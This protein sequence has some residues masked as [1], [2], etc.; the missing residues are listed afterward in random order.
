MGA[1]Q[2][3]EDEI[4]IISIRELIAYLSVDK[5][6]TFIALLGIA[7]GAT[8]LV[9]MDT[10]SGG[11]KKKVEAELG[12]L[13]ALLVMIVPGQVKSIGQ[14]RIQFSRYTTLK[15]EDIRRIRQKIPF[16]KDASAIKKCSL[17]VKAQAN[18][19]RLLISGV[20]PSYF[21]LLDYKVD[22]GRILVPDDVKRKRKVVVL[23]AKT[24]ATFFQTGSNALARV[25]DIGGVSFKVIGVLKKRGG[26][27]NEDFDETLFVP[28]STEMT[29]LENV[30]F[31]D[32]AVVQVT[33]RQELDEAIRD[34]DRFLVMRHGKRDFTLN[35]YQE[36]Q[37]TAS[38]TLRLFST[39][40]RIVAFVA[41]SVGTLGILAV[42]ALSIY[43]RLLEIAIKRV[44]GA[45]KKD[46]FFQFLSESMILS[47]VGSG[48]GIIFS[49]FVGVIVQ[50]AARWPFFVPIDTIW[51]SII[52][53]LL[54][55]VSAGLYPAVKALEFEP[56]TILRLFEEQ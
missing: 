8:S 30:D 27:S 35:T 4:V 34:I 56:R 49:I 5:K 39:L 48:V 7:M 43:E 23:G 32:G 45:R 6:R 9:L 18:E 14:R 37:G 50:L 15:L 42:M 41:F 24:A 21:H 16:V 28:L 40:S 44:A 29:V 3:L 55:G 47:L 31:L 25:I 22:R 33:S 26:F 53:S 12:K 54:T 1:R 20:E 46:I 11:M 38:K 36:V 51:I 13:G 17:S 19:S 2:G 52:L 10:I